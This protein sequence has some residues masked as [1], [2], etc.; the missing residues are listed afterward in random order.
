MTYIKDIVEYNI[1]EFKKLEGEVSDLLIKAFSSHNFVA[2]ND[3]GLRMVLLTCSNCN[4]KF[5]AL[6]IGELNFLCSKDYLRNLSVSDDGWN[7]V[8]EEH[9]IRDILE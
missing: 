1:N 9:I 6:K 7:L 8:C 3:H 4:M 5:G 2:C